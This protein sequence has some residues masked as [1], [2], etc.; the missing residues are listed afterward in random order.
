M[1]ILI[2]Q[3]N[4]LDGGAPKDIYLENGIVRKVAVGIEPDEV[5]DIIEA[6]G[7]IVISGLV[8]AHAHLDKSLI[9]G[10][11][12]YFDE[13]PPVRA[14]WVRDL[15]QGFTKEDIKARARKVIEMSIE[16][17]VVGIRTNVDV[18][19]LVGLRGVEALLE[20][21]QEMAENFEIQVVAFN[22]E[23]FGRFPR[24]KELLEESLKMGAD[25]VGGHTSMDADAKKE[26]IDLIFELAARYQ[27]DIDFHADETG[28]PD[29][30]MLPY[31]IEKT[32]AEGYQDRVNAIHCCSMAV[33]SEED[34]KRDLEG[35]QQAKINVV[36]CPTAIA[37]RKLTEV[38][39]MLSL[40]IS[41]GVGTDNIQD[42]F[43][44]LG[45]G[46]LWEIG[47][48]L[49]YVK[50]FYDDAEVD[51]LFKMLTNS[52]RAFAD[53]SRFAIREGNKAKICLLKA[54]RPADI[55]RYNGVI[56][57]RVT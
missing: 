12:P 20:L 34:V 43:N 11:R 29:D 13:P 45:N 44:P 33:I 39:R 41:L 21:K 53:I 46:N 48:L 47:Q 40:G 10:R 52:N 5:T 54:S 17:G 56:E 15:K 18:D 9:I 36:V 31:L 4:L 2:R 6:Q 8:N 57:C 25:C 26:H 50:R 22:Q 49:A 51:A 3:A 23:G 14:G 7:R 19:P 30:H 55:F 24:T 38:K 16:S 37:T 35:L 28:R 1:K 27:V 42:L 32:I